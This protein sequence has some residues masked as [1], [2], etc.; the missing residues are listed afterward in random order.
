MENL[1]VKTK[2]NIA[3]CFFEIN[4]LCLMMSLTIRN[5]INN[6]KNIVPGTQYKFR[7]ILDK[8]GDA[9][10]RTKNNALLVFNLVNLSK[11]I[12]IP[13]RVNTVIKLTSE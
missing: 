11:Q 2:N 8:K 4:L 10:S 6:G 7:A 1:S 5:I 3:S 13:T 9:K 12:I